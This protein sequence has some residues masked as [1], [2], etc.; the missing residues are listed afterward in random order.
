MAISARDELK[1]LAESLT[2]AEAEV[3]LAA[4][5]LRHARVGRGR[6]RGGRRAIRLTAYQCHG[7][8]S[9]T[10]RRATN[11]AVG[12]PAGGGRRIIV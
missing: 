5:A 11:A 2:E 4:P 1:H 8:V 3:Y 7:A 9:L 10:G 12:A 6:S